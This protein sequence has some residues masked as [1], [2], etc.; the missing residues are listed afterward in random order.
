MREIGRNGVEARSVAIAKRRGWKAY[1]WKASNKRGVADH[2]FVR[3]GRILFVEFK[4]PGKRPR[5]QQNKRHRELREEGF[6]VIVIDHP[7]Q[8]HDVFA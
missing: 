6:D 1:K 4:A 3:R 7:D 5:R 2:I 8:A